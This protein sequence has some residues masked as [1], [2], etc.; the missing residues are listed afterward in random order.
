VS[1]GA[2]LFRIRSSVQHPLKRHTYKSVIH[3]VSDRWWTT[4]NKWSVAVTGGGG[5][6]G[7]GGGSGVGAVAI[8]EGG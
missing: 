8:N 2:Q 6:G 1:E 4:K 3:T 5:G 7:G